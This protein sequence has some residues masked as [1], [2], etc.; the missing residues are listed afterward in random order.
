MEFRYFDVVNPVKSIF[1]FVSALFLF[2]GTIG[3]DMFKH[4]CEEDGMEVSYFVKDDSVCDSH[5]HD[6]HIADKGM[7]EAH[8]SSC[9]EEDSETKGCCT[10][11]VKHVQVKLDFVNNILVKPV[12]IT[13]LCP[14]LVWIEGVV[15]E[16]EVIR[17][18]SGNDPPPI[19]TGER[20]S[21]TQTWLI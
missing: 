5:E 7:H 20:L 16:E 21:K 12:L 2:V 17:A 9:C 19:T 4:V 6:E 1:L 11:E 15:V 3:V 14:K 8:Q 13:D 10:T 18:A